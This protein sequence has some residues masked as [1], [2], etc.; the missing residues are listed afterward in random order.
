MVSGK[1]RIKEL[2]RR[3]KWP[4]WFAIAMAIFASLPDWECRIQ[5]WVGAAKMM[6]GYIG[7]AAVIADSRW[8][9]LGLFVGG[10]LYIAFVGESKRALRHP[11]LSIFGWALFGLIALAFYSVTLIGYA[12]LHQPKEVEVQV[13]K[14][15][16]R[17]FTPAQ[18]KSS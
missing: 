15:N 9:P 13:Q 6:P 17:K 14:E 3:V 12:T 4:G 2:F 5:F 16:R 7:Y 18:S 8:F 10:F 11:I 1:R